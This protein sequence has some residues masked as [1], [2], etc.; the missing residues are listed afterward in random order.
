VSSLHV[1][2]RRGAKM[3]SFDVTRWGFVVC[4]LFI[5]AAIMYLGFLAKP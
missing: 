3:S 4:G 1:K 2:V 5:V